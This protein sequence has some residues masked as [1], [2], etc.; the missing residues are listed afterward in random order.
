MI[1]QNEATP[2]RGLAPRR[3]ARLY[4]PVR[5]A[6]PLLISVLLLINFSPLNHVQAKKKPSRKHH[7]NKRCH[8]KSIQAPQ[9][10]PKARP[11]PGP[12]FVQVGMASW[13]G[14]QFHG[15]RTAS[16]ER[17]NMYALTAAHRSLRFNTL[18]KVTNLHNGRQVVVRIND[19]GPWI[20]GRIIDLS[21]AAAKEIGMIERGCVRVRIETIPK[22]ETTSPVASFDA[23]R[24]LPAETVEGTATKAGDTAQ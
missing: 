10:R 7:H 9:C 23:P 6:F 15:L 22:I 2:L 11:R 3:G 1:E 8:C 18:V 14:R 13:Y 5:R 4:R 17:F 20:G 12:G 16:G 19:R 21:Y 24:T